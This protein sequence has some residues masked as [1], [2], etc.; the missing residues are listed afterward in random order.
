MLPS[1]YGAIGKKQIIQCITEIEND[2][3]YLFH[4]L[5]LPINYLKNCIDSYIHQNILV[6]FIVSPELTVHYLN[7]I[8][9]PSEFKGIH[10]INIYNNYTQIILSRIG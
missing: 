9:L 4:G 7:Y 6:V 5:N 3:V 2:K 8:K 10:K 1:K